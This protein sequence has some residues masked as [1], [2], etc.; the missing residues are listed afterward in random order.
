MPRHERDENGQ[1]CFHCIISERLQKL[2]RVHS[3]K[4]CPLITRELAQVLA[5]YM[6]C[7]APAGEFP[8]A[9]KTIVEYFEQVAK[10]SRA[11][12]VKQGWVNEATVQ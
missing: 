1:P 3:K 8:S 12:A 4:E 11:A 6:A 10:E 5:E 7:T 9:L 2:T